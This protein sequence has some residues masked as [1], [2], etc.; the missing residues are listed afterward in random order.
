MEGVS[1]LGVDSD[2]FTP[3]A[4]H[5]QDA[6]NAFR[7]HLQKLHVY[8]GVKESSLLVGLALHVK[9]IMQVSEWR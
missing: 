6:V 8:A 7:Q 2:D 3:T 5:H 1:Q 4:T 9:R